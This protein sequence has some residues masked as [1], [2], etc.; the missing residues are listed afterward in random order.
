MMIFF[1]YPAMIC[2]GA[3]IVFLSLAGIS[4]SFANAGTIVAAS[5]ICTLGISLL[6]W[7]PLCW[8]VGWTVFK[9][10]SLLFGQEQMRRAFGIATN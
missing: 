4:G 3:S 10:C 6:I 2:L 1:R 9:I 7:I 5:I 8:V